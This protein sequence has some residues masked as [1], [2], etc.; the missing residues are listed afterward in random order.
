MKSGIFA[1]KL[2]RSLSALAWEVSL[3][4]NDATIRAAALHIADLGI[5]RLQLTHKHPAW[6]PPKSI[7]TLR[8][9]SPAVSTTATL[10]LAHYSNLIDLHTDVE[11]LHESPLHRPDDGVLVVSGDG[12]GCLDSLGALQLMADRPRRVG[13]QPLPMSVVYTCHRDAINRDAER[14]RFLRK[15]RAVG[16]LG[17]AGVYIQ[18]CD[19]VDVLQNEV[20]WLRAAAPQSTV[21]GCLL[22]PSR[23]L[24]ATFLTKPWRGSSLSSEFIGSIDGARRRNEALWSAYR[25]LDLEPLIEMPPYPT[26]QH[27]GWAA[28][29][30][31][32]T[33]A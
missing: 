20:G 14:A 33:R 7:C 11:L 18:L 24:L 25:Q 23:S 2:P 10:S 22:L 29:P 6:G 27:E 15:C 16:D 8:E 5:Q 13:L 1:D 30:E 28:L 32:C 26:R 3:P 31:L 9:R 19:D 17:I 12:T 21:Y 4:R